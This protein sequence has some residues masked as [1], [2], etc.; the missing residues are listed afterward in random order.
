[1]PNSL[2]ETIKNRAA[3]KARHA[4]MMLSIVVGVIIVAAVVALTLLVSATS[5]PEVIPRTAADPGTT[6]QTYVAHNPDTAV[7]ESNLAF[8]RDNRL[9]APAASCGT[10]GHWSL[11]VNPED[12]VGYPYPAAPGAQDWGRAADAIAVAMRIC[13]T[14]VALTWVGHDPRHPASDRWTALLPA[15]AAVGIDAA[16]LRD[17]AAHHE[18]QV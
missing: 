4:L 15:S 13:A 14:D 11:D 7:T 6:L 12:F 16:A 1:M 8:A 5:T 10:P 9:V 18:S 2:G 3:M 17:Y